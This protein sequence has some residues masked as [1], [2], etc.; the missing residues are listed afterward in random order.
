M[1]TLTDTHLKE[2]FID[3]SGLKE[4]SIAL[5][6]NNVLTDYFTDYSGKKSRVGNIYRGVV[7]KI[8]RSLNAAFVDIGLEKHGFLSASDV[9]PVYGNP[10]MKVIGLS[11]RGRSH[12]NI[13]S[14]LKEG[15][16]VTVQ[17]LKDPVESKG[18]A[19]T[20]W[21]SVPGRMTVLLPGLEGIGVSH[22]IVDEKERATG[23][24]LL[25]SA[26][27][28]LGSLS[29]AA[30]L[31]TQGLG[32]TKSDL[33]KD[34][35]F[36]RR[37]WDT[38]SNDIEKAVPGK[39]I[40]DDTDTVMRILRDYISADYSRIVCPDEKTAAS[41]SSIWKIMIPRKAPPVFV[42]SGN[43]TVFTA[44]EIDKQLKTLEDIKVNLPS[45]GYLYIES[46]KALTAID[47]NSGKSAF[48]AMKSHEAAYR[49]NIE[50]VT[51][52]IRQIRLRD[53]GG[54]IA[55][56]L[57][58]MENSA[59]RR[60]CERLARELLKLG[61]QKHSVEK[62]NDFGLLILSRQRTRINI[63]NAVF[64]PCSICNGT[65]KK[66]SISYT[67]DQAAGELRMAKSRSM[68][69]S[70]RI[71]GSKRFMESFISN[72]GDLIAGPGPRITI[73]I[74]ESD[75][76][77]FE[78]AI[79]D[80]NGKIVS[81]DN[82]P[83]TTLKSF[84]GNDRVNAPERKRSR[85]KKRPGAAKAV[86]G[87]QDQVDVRGQETGAQENEAG[88]V[89]GNEET[90]PVAG[91]QGPK[92]VVGN[93][94][95]GQ[96][97]GKQGPKP[98][99][100]KQDQ[101]QAAGKQ[102]QSA[103]KQGPRPVAGNQE[104]GQ[105]AGKQEPR[106][107][108]GKQEQ[109]QAAGNQEQGQAAGN[110]EPRPVAGNQEQGQAVGKQEPRPV[111]GKQGQG[112]VAG[113][114]DQAAGKQEP[115]PES[116]KQVQEQTAQGDGNVQVAGKSSGTRRRRQSAAK[117]IVETE[118][119]V[120]TLQDKSVNETENVLPE[121]KQE[122]KTSPVKNMAK[123]PKKQ[124]DSRDSIM[125]T[126]SEVDTNVK[127]PGTQPTGKLKEDT[128]ATVEKNDTEKP[129]QQGNVP[130]VN[131][132][133]SRRRGK[134]KPVVI[135]D[136]PSAAAKPEPKAETGDESHPEPKSQEP[137]NAQNGITVSSDTSTEGEVKKSKSNRRR[138]W[139]KKEKPIPA[140]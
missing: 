86:T 89:V 118:K 45:G 14:L 34:L 30:I 123:R 55:I 114:Q 107:A 117:S 119:V 52:A 120:A 87:T 63:D 105:A 70:V 2:M 101:E 15:A 16:L 65:G 103:G 67:V 80:K 13:E 135:G 112:Q 127:I 23:R 97:A 125:G 133:H 81:S 113:R 48:R 44:F 18:Y 11:D 106:P 78:I 51:E 82:A 54:I 131:K 21:L 1:N 43:Q 10:E 20:T 17:V 35:K 100:G 46:V 24:K 108:A 132:S 58:D 31:R 98:A 12:H 96:A 39:L 19:I 36:C 6:E 60:E 93:Q 42:Y 92:P 32:A 40:Y 124:P 94:E 72:W 7:R 8:D 61:K 41:V 77:D 116:E 22:K 88:R 138:W 26:F 85:R 62:I 140:S 50:A 95:Q 9:H 136:A 84:D 33:E 47:V 128:Q 59:H 71:S 69:H 79:L 110:Q 134:A 90:K 130:P 27:T 129:L 64:E 76:T 91:N 99:A 28:S 83:E 68:A 5:T 115:R 122:L 121:K 56:D 66:R 139:K 4:T 53:I 74:S 25:A 29:A 57:I 3:I 102:G 126:S 38:I 37:L 49:T 111:A 73:S 137:P 109:G 104:Q 75:D